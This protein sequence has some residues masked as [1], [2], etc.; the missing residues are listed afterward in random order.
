MYID[1]TIELGEE[2]WYVHSAIHA[3]PLFPMGLLILLL[4]F[5]LNCYAHPSP[6]VSLCSI[7]EVSQ[8]TPIGHF[9][10][11]CIDTQHNNVRFCF[12]M[13]VLTYSGTPIKQTSVVKRATM[14]QLAVSIHL[15]QDILAQQVIHLRSYLCSISFPISLSLVLVSAY[16]KNC[17]CTCCFFM[18]IAF[19]CQ[20]PYINA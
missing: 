14:A 2:C 9:T 1:L 17:T 4:V 10:C 20:F 5:P 8:V 13:Y 6:F 7:V 3:Q 12:A 19:Y 16:P 15:C 18:R 11:K